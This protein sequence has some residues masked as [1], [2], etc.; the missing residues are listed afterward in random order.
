MIIVRSARVRLAA[1]LLLAGAALSACVVGPN[2]RRPPV[3]TPPHFKEAEGWTPANPADGIDKGAWWGVF[4]DPVLDGLERKVEIS[5]QTLAAA[6][7]AYREAHA[8]VAE[9]RAQ[10]FPTIGLTGSA[11]TS[12]SGKTSSS[13]GTGSSGASRQYK[14]GGDASWAPDLWG[15]IRRTIEAAHATAQASAADVANARLSAQSELAIDYF[16]LRMSDADKAMLTETVTAYQKALTVTQNKYNV[17]VAARSDVL[18]AQ[19]QLTNAKAD[20]VD[21]DRQRTAAEHAI[22]VLIGQPPADLTIEPV[23]D[24]SPGPPATPLQVPSTILQRR[25]DVAAAERSA[26]AANAQIGVA[27]SAY[28]PSLSLTAD[29]GVSSGA[30][31]ALFNSS[32]TFWSLG[33]S[34]SETLLD[35]GAR[36]A[37]VAQYR[38]AYDQ[39]VAQYRQTVLT[40]F[41]NV[42]DALAAARVLQDE[43]ALRAEAADQAQQNVTITLNEYKAGTVDY[44]T[45]AAAQATALSARES[46][47]SVQASR[48]TE[49]VD[50]IQALGG[51]WSADELKGR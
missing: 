3:A 6:E 42:E 10:L 45:V 32:A 44:T 9:D 24:W 36:K 49:A 29:G 37:A 23:A 48:M 39:T 20:L 15:K 22:A 47:I 4:N 27:V 33:A 25:P 40:A 16:Q 21:L 14:V 38:A 8:I 5:N 28:F 17:G 35:F 31:G 19:T 26:A 7:A 1:G 43:Q 34:V 30:L 46:L 50:L 11:T 12:R 41:Q 13:S 2:Y 51:G 18:T